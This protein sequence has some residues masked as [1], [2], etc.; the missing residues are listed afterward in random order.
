MIFQYIPI[1]DG[2]ELIHAPQQSIRELES[3]RCR[4]FQQQTTSCNPWLEPKSNVQLRETP[5]I[6]SITHRSQKAIRLLC[7][8][9]L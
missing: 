6:Y 8:F 4:N 7:P 9:S 2:K 1:E 3:M 5:D